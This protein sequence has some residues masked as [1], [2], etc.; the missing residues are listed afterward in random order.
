VTAQQA[1]RTLWKAHFSK[2][3]LETIPENEAGARESLQRRL[4][5]LGKALAVVCLASSIAFNLVGLLMPRPMGLWHLALSGPAL[6]QF[7][8]GLLFIVLWLVCRRGAQG[9]RTLEA[10]DAAAAV[11]VGMSYAFAIHGAESYG[12][13][14]HS[15]TP[16][17]AVLSALLCAL[18]VLMA[19]AVLIPSSPGRTLVVSAVASLPTVVEAYRATSVDLSGDAFSAAAALFALM[20]S[21]VTIALCTLASRVVF[22]LRQTVQDARKLGQYV[23]VERIG[24]GGMGVVYRAEHAMLRRPTAV[25]LLAPEKM[26]RGSIS[27]FEREVMLTS[28]LTHPNTIAIYDFG[29]STDG[30]FYYA[31]EYLDG[32][33]LRDLVELNG[34]VPP[35]RV[36]YLMRQVASSLEEAHEL[37]LVHRDIKPENI[38]VNDRGG[39]CDWVKVLDFGLV[40][41]TRADASDVLSEANTIMGT[42]SYMS[43]EAIT[44]PASVAPPSDIYSVGAVAYY[45]LTGQP[46]FSGDTPIEVCLRHLTETPLPPSLALGRPIPRAVEDVVLSCLAKEP[47]NRPLS[48]RAL[49]QAFSSLEGPAWTQREAR[50][51]WRENEELLSERKKRQDVAPESR[52]TVLRELSVDY[53]VNHWR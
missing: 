43:P 27:R 2:L 6:S 9:R 26:G 8:A 35:A 21:A 32:V 47:A 14:T 10:L 37:G 11:L 28:R 22:G 49:E 7:R 40:K 5:L 53:R 42:P 20:W 34:P 29:S 45:L 51:W 30:L 3:A 17:A 48:A 15:P 38:I 19:R 24:T 33:T 39:M 23:L 50:A 12:L 25:K 46:V 16:P 52:T 18:V 41:D 31:M 36:A 13:R 44:T 4:A 1:H